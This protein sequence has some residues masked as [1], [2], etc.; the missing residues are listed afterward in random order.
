MSGGVRGRRQ[1]PSPT[2]SLAFSIL[3]NAEDITTYAKI[4]M[5]ETQSVKAGTIRYVNQSTKYGAQYFYNSYWGN[6][7]HEAGQQCNLASQSMALSYIGIN[8]LPA[9]MK[10]GGSVAENIAGSGAIIDN[11]SSV[12][13]GV[14]RMISGNGKYSPVIIYSGNYPSY[15]SSYQHWVIVVGRVAGTSNQYY[16]CDPAYG[17]K[18]AAYYTVAINGNILTSYNKNATIA[19]FYQLYNP[20]GN[21]DTEKPT[22]SDVQQKNISFETSAAE[23]VTSSN[24]VISS[25]GRNNGM[26]Q[27]LGF[28]IGMDGAYQNQSRIVV[29]KDV[30]WTDFNMR[31][32]VDSYY[33]MLNPGQSY[34][35]SFFCV[36]E[37]HEYK[38]EEAVF[39]T[40]GN[41]RISFDSVSVSDV[42]SVDA[43]IKCWGDN[44]YG[45][46]L[47]TVGFEIS[48]GYNS[49]DKK[50]YGVL[51][52]KTWTRPE[53]T[54]DLKDY[55]GNLKP[56]TNYY[57]RFYADSENIRYYSDY[58][59]FETLSDAVKFDEVNISNVTNTNAELSVWMSNSGTIN[60][61][62]LYIG[63]DEH[64]QERVAYTQKDVEWTRA[65]IVMDMTKYWKSL[66]PG[67][68]YTYVFYAKKGETEYRSKP[69]QFTTT[70]NKKISF[71]T[72]NISNITDKS[73]KLGVWF[74]NDKA[75]DITSV[76]I[77]IREANYSECTN[78]EVLGNV[79]WTRAYLDYN[80][81]DYYTLL[82]ANRSYNVRYYIDV[83]GERYYSE[84]SQFAT[85]R[86]STA[87]VISD[88]KIVEVTENGYTVLCNVKDNTEVDRVV[89]ST[90]TE[91]NGQDD[92]VE[93]E[94]NIN[95]NIVSCR[96]QISNHNGEKGKYITNI[97][98]YDVFN[99][100]SE[101]QI[102]VEIKDK[103]PRLS[104]LEKNGNLVASV[105]NT[106]HVT[107]Y[108]FVYG[109]QKDITLET[110]GRTRV[111]Y[112]NLNSNGSYSLDATELTD[113]TIRAYAVYTAE[114]GTIQVI[115]SDPISR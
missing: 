65:N 14:D 80:I 20:R 101:Q 30:E 81:E 11:P 61:I 54:F 114:D 78:F 108:G 33:G 22:I 57:V 58:R 35:Y 110:P 2:R 15:S 104:L 67:Q 5:N 13:A 53:F 55:C 27:E 83:E 113:C 85:M 8:R 56:E 93:T 105:F 24:A 17:I 63:D 79:G 89:F 28:Y 9:A 16:V 52:N 97:S 59:T 41:K 32:D 107:E 4:E 103:S 45:Q 51:E 25:W 21:I 34:R 77:E 36:K 19:G 72:I 62:G 18:M 109:K 10:V 115:Y 38:S 102:S 23:N 95:G 99:N 69:G 49:V 1:K 92:L 96:I 112:S 29:S 87:P 12:S 88:I 3:V 43:K 76:G 37:G 111:A 42:S 31:Y 75:Y 46:V 60:E 90:W 100:K 47:A 7:V 94:G 74:S 82:K 84:F 26:M 66:K 39:T 106:D 91:K 73:A 71:E 70:G 6:N 50:E 40:S 44:P 98:V 64:V 48:I 86:D 68:T